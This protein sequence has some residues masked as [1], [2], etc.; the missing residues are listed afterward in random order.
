[1]AIKLNKAFPRLFRRRTEKLL[2]KFDNSYSRT[3]SCEVWCFEM[4]PNMKMVSVNNDVYEI[5]RM[6]K[7]RLGI[8]INKQVEQLVMGV[9]LE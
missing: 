8:P 4:N 7:S 6:R 9:K 3:K 5:L 2:Y 1:M